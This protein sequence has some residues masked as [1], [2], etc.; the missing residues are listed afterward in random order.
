MV[1]QAGKLYSLQRLFCDREYHPLTQ[2]FSILSTGKEVL[3]AH[4]LVQV[5][6]YIL[7]LIEELFPAW[8][9]HFSVFLSIP[10]LT[11]REQW[12][13]LP[14]AHNLQELQLGLMESDSTRVI[15]LLS[16]A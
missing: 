1:E 13:I 15:Q 7:T 6:Q 16:P 2:V 3:E 10:V 12:T 14:F 5:R 8:L 11:C 9:D 4:V